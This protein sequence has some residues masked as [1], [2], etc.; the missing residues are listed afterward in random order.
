MLASLAALLLFSH[1]SAPAPPPLRLS[2]P[3][4]RLTLS[5]GLT[6]IL[7]PDRRLPTVTLHLRFGVGS[8]DERPGRTGFAH[9][10]EHLM[11]MGTRSVPEGVLD[12]LVEQGGGE[13][14]ASTS[15]DRTTYIDQGP[16]NLLETF[17]WLER[18]RLANLGEDMTQAKLDLQRDVV[19]NELRQR[20]ETPP[21]GLQEVLLARHLYPAGHPYQHPICGSHGDLSAASLADVREFFRTWYVPSNASL[22]I[23]GDFEPEHARRLV[24]RHLSP[25]PRSQAPLRALPQRVQLARPV[26]IVQKA[27]IQNERVVLAWL[28]PGAWEP[29]DAELALLREALTSGKSSRLVRSLVVDQRLAEDVVVLYG[30]AT[31]QSVYAIVATAQ[32]GHTAAELERALETEL[33]RLL[34]AP[35]T[36][37]EVERARAF[38]QRDALTSLEIPS[39]RADQLNALQ[40]RFGDPGLLERL[41]LGRYDEL[42]SSDVTEVVRRVLGR[43]RL[44]LA[45]A[46]TT[47]TEKSR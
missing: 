10:F 4:E 46:P 23:A 19:R 43:P 42:T 32:G 26:R 39:A 1:P 47:G 28:G 27:K 18:D 17:L 41:S 30:P 38:V 15:E 11:F 25:L 22:V 29:G 2:V 3:F 31:A 33:A 7:Q 35:L 20:Y 16:S 36:L 9:L 5:N 44:T 37:A 40:A 45:F 8:A 12:Q 21:Y 13:T 34:T 14:N 24:E 6:V